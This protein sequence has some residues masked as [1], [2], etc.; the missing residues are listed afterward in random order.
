M[1]KRVSYGEWRLLSRRDCNHQVQGEAGDDVR[2]DEKDPGANGEGGEPG[3]QGV[4]R[5]R[6]V[7]SLNKRTESSL[8]LA[9]GIGVWADLGTGDVTPNIKFHYPSH[10]EFA[11]ENS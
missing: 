9:T 11:N 3:G 5:G 6:W 1:P 8:S 7:L 4:L 10:I 2:G